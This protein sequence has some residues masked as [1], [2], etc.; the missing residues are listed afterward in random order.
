MASSSALVLRR[1]AAW[2]C[3]CCTSCFTH[4][5]STAH[6]CFTACHNM[7]WRQ[8]AAGILHVGNI[9][10]AHFTFC[11]YFSHEV[12]HALLSVLPRFMTSL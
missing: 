6:C 1:R 8:W 2:R 9:V 7:E 5:T 10:F 3:L 11:G 4:S 12:A